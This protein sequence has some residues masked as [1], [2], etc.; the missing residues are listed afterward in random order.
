[1]QITPN[2]HCIPLSIV[3]AFLIVK[4]DG[5]TL[6]DTGLPKNEKKIL[7]YIEE[8][9]RKPNDLKR[10]LLTHADGD[11][12]GS[13]K[14]LRELTRA[15]IYASEYEAECAAKGMPPREPKLSNPLLKLLFSLTAKMFVYPPTTVDE[16][17]K[18]GDVL[19][20]LGGLRV[21]NTPGHTPDHVSY[22][23]P[24]HNILLAGD[25]LRTSKDRIY[26]AVSPFTWDEAKQNQSVKLQADLKP[27]IVCVGH[28]DVVREA[29]RKFKL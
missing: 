24:S 19:P 2:L 5:L 18:D 10:I 6:V 27:Q 17:V 9:G 15:K 22:F 12:V 20:I 21:I 28:G 1:M 25:S 7:K 16:I 29:D 3:N 8:I 13:A 14:A 26:N 11:H 4:D 23:S